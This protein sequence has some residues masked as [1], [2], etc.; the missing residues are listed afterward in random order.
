MTGMGATRW[1]DLGI[2][3]VQPSEMMKLGLILALAHYFHDLEEA[4]V[5]RLVTLLPPFLL[6][7]VPAALVLRQPDLGTA[8]MVL[9]IGTVILFVAGLAIWKRSEEPPSEL[10]SLMRHSYAV[11]CF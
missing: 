9:A 4:Q 2:V 6:M 1:L 5:N 3:S 10:P 7:A 11:Y 8:L